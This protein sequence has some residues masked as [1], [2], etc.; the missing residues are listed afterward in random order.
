MKAGSKLEF[1]VYSSTHFKLM[2]AYISR[3]L[4]YANHLF[5]SNH[6]RAFLF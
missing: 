3:T 6:P 2:S 5:K 4:D 1:E